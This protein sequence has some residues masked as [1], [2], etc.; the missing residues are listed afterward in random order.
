MCR[1]VLMIFF[2]FCLAGSG[3]PGS[4]TA[5]DSEVIQSDSQDMDARFA[6]GRSLWQE[7][8]Y[9]KAL[10]AYLQV[11]EQSDREDLLGEQFA[12]ALPGEPVYDELCALFRTRTRE[13]WHE[14][15]ADTDACCHPVY[16]LEEALASAPVRALGML[17]DVGLRPPVQLSDQRLPPPTPAPL[18]GQHTDQVLSE[19]GY[20]EAMVDDLRSR[21]VV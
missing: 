19:L 13:E 10:E 3:W 9:V 17:T 12:P 15:L 14:M 7:R 16:D 6:Q 4:I 21:G 18:L 5:S 11:I 2:S 8:D 1:R 20:D